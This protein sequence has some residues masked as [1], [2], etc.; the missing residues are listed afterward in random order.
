MDA[1]V[2]VSKAAALGICTLGLPGIVWVAEAEEA[3]A[4]V[5]LRRFAPPP[6]RYG[7]L[8]DSRDCPARC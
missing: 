1:M 4:P 5:E 3:S 7:P 6:L 2:A 8:G